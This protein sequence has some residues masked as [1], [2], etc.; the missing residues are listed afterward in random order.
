MK[1]ERVD[2]VRHEWFYRAGLVH[3]SIFCRS[4]VPQGTR[5]L[6]DGLKL[7]VTIAHGFGTKETVKHFDLY[8]DIVPAESAVNFGIFT[9]FSQLRC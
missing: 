5:V 6:S 1:R 4:A 2:N 7:D 8:A 9:K 3:I